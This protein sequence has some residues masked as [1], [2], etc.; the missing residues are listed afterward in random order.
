MQNWPAN[1]LVFL[2]FAIIYTTCSVY[3][4]HKNIQSKDFSISFSGDAQIEI[5]S[6]FAG[7][8]FHHSC[9]VPQRISF[10]YP[11]ANSIDQSTGYWERDSSYLMAMGLE[12]NGKQEWLNYSSFAFKQT[13]YSVKFYKSD[14]NKDISIT[15]QFTHNYPAII[16]HL[17]IKNTSLEKTEYT[18]KSMS[19]LSLRTSHTYACIN[20]AQVTQLNDHGDVVIS[21]PFIE[22]DSAKLF[23]LNMGEYPTNHWFASSIYDNSTK[24][25]NWWEYPA[26][27][28]KQVLMGDSTIPAA[29]YIYSKTLEPNQILSIIQIIG[30]CA[31]DETDSIITEIKLNYESE[32]QKFE[33]SVINKSVKDN[34]FITGD[35]ILDHSVLWAKSVIEVNR[36]YIDGYYPIM[37]CPA[38]YNFF[39]THDLFL[40]D[41]AVVKYNPLQVKNDLVFLVSRAN[42]DK[43]IPHAYYWKDE[44][45][46]TEYSGFDNWNHFWFVILSASFFKHSGDIDFMNNIYPLI[47]KSISLIMDNEIK[48]G[49]VYSYRPDWWD[50]GRNYGP[51]AYMTIL[52]NKALRD[53]IYI[54]T[55]L[56][57]NEDKIDEF[58]N[59]ASNLKKNLVNK[60][61]SD[62]QNYLINYL[63]DGSE[64]KHY[65]MGSLLSIFYDL[66][67]NLK[68]EKLIKT[69]QQELLDKK[70]GIKNVSPM[71][72]HEKQEQYGLRNGEEGKVGIYFNGGVWSHSNAFY[73]LSLIHLNYRN[74]ASDF[75]KRN[76]TIQGIMNSPNGQ[77]AMYEYRNANYND[78]KSYGKIDK[79]QFSWAASWYLYSLYNLIGVYES[80]WNIYFN[81][82]LSENIQNCQFTLYANGYRYDVTITGKGDYVKSIYYDDFLFPSL[83]IPDKLQKRAS[84]SIVL[85]NPVTPYLEK[86][87][88]LLRDIQWDESSKIMKL[89]IRTNYNKVINLQLISPM[90][91]LLVEL[92]GQQV[93]WH[94]LKLDESVRRLEIVLGTLK[95]KNEVYIKFE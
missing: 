27:E 71:D 76:M 86:C 80:D 83:V 85:G 75:I 24:G 8:E 38:E 23:Y 31:K 51:R 26:T 73:A 39:F 66:L 35:S 59:T 30:M 84:V 60:L 95:Q 92:N 77:P 68:S 10:Y 46:I 16:I 9:P 62:K 36:H 52:A 74:E 14:D 58:R 32:I 18:F 69:V 72:F 43:I 28:E 40:T 82:W 6:H 65:Y 78:R 21:Y 1:R 50:A 13:P 2:L 22:T 54:S 12:V 57:L 81:P 33:E 56:G 91:T 41:L 48:S 29:N 19:E 53:F 70:L 34:H 15:Y 42:N 3:E 47:E 64:D 11:V 90:A 89:N 5:G 63:H 17:D 45:F 79:S 49:L 93:D 37:P 20:S 87:N 55:K 61:W 67:D 25:Y 88:A 94:E 44:E 4:S 7:I